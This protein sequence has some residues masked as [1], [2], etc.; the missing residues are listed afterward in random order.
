[1]DYALFYSSLDQPLARWSSERHAPHWDQRPQNFSLLSSSPQ[2]FIYAA[3]RIHGCGISMPRGV[4]LLIKDWSLISPNPKPNPTRSWGIHHLLGWSVQ[5]GIMRFFIAFW[6]TSFR[7][8]SLV[9]IIEILKKRRAFFG[10]GRP[11]LRHSPLNMLLTVW[12]DL[13]A[14]SHKHENWISLV[15]ISTFDQHR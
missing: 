15:V 3:K 7:F 4:N 2:S 13:H 11:I 14:E 9:I 10:G 12:I 1:M 6:A 8:R 5:K